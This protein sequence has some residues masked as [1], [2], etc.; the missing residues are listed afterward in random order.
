MKYLIPPSEGKTLNNTLNCVFKDTKFPLF[1]SVEKVLDLLKTKKSDSDIQSIYGTSLEK[2][3]DL[4]NKNLN[5]I[6]SP[7]SL[8]IDRYSGVVFKNVE[9]SGFNKKMKIFFNNNFFIFSGMF[10][11]VAPMSKIPFYKLKMNVLGLYKFWSPI[12]TKQLKDEDLIVD[13]LPQIHRKAY[14]QDDRTINIDFF[15]IKDGKK[16]NAGHLG[17]SVK[18]QFIRFICENQ[19]ENIDDFSAFNYNDFVWDGNCIIKE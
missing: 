16:V 15:H 19:I 4:H 11:I 9:W 1:D 8:A 18:G 14:K 13:L 2:S 3:V 7:C 5:I 10:G 12:L 6:N 17:K